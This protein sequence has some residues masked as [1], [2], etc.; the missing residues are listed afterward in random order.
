MANSNS[1]SNVLRSVANQEAPYV[2]PRPFR[3]EDQD[4][5]FGRNQE[6]LELTSL[7][8][9]HPEVLLYAP[10]GA[11]KSSLLYA[12]VMPILED[13]EEFDVLPAAR[14]RSQESSVIPDE[15]INNI[16]VFNAL[17]DL[18]DDKLSVMQRAQTTLAEYLKRQPRALVEGPD[19]S[20][21]DRR[22]E[23]GED[24]HEQR[25]PRV[26]VFDQFEEIF[27]LYPERYQDRQDFFCQVA[28]ALEGD[29]FLRVVFSMRED[30]IAELEPYIDV[31]PQK[32]RTRFR[33][34]RLRKANAISAVKQPLETDRVKKAGRSFAPGAA[35]S[36][37]EKLMLIK[38]K[39]ASG[40]KK[41]VPGEFVDPVQLQVVCQ[42][43]WEKLPSTETVI[44]QADLDKYANVDEALLDFYENSIRKAVAAS[45][46]GSEATAGVAGAAPAGPAVTEGALRGWFEQV[47]ITRE[48]KRNMVF[49]E[50]ETT[51]GLPNLVVD[52]L[53]NQHLVRVEMRG[54]EPWYELSHDRFIP[55]IKES[56]RRWLL[57]QPLAQ[58]KA[59]ELEA[60]ASEWLAAGRNSKLLLDRGQLADARTWLQSSEAAAIGYSETLYSLI[61]ESETE[62]EQEDRRH[63]KALAAEQHRRMLAE[64]QRA[65]QLKVGFVVASV[66]LVVTAVSAVSAYRAENRATKNYTRAESARQSAEKAHGDAVAAQI[67]EKAAA[68]LAEGEAARATK[69]AAAARSAANE[70][71]IAKENES[72]ARRKAEDARR[73]AETDRGLAVAA[74]AAAEGASNKLAAA[75]GESED[76]KNRAWS[77]KLAG[78]SNLQLS[79]DP[80]LGLRLAIEAVKFSQTAPATYSL[81]QSYLNSKAR[82]ILKGH[83]NSVWQSV[84]SPDGKFIFTASEDGTVKMWDAKTNRELKALE[85]QEDGVHRVTTSAD[86]TH[87][88]T[89]ANAKGRVWNLNDGTSIVLDGLTGPVAAIAFS[90]NGKLVATEATSDEKKPG[91]VP[92]IWDATSGLERHKLEGHEEAVSAL[93][94]S[95]DGNLLATSSW[96]S[97]ARIWDVATGRQL[98]I[99]R[100]HTAP[101]TSV[102]FDPQGGRLVTG[103]YDGTARVWE[104][105]TGKEIFALR[106]E[107]AGG[108]RDV[109][110]SPNGALILTVGQRLTALT[111]NNN[112]IPL[113]AGMATDENA[114]ADNAVRVWDATTGRQVVV[115]DGLKMEANQAIFSPD[116]RMI[117]TA[118][119]DGAVQLW[120]I[121]TGKNIAE[122]KGHKDG[123][124]SVAFSPDGNSVVTAGEDHTA[125]VWRV[126]NA[127]GAAQRF[128]S[129]QTKAI[130]RVQ[131][132]FNGETIVS[133]S[134]DGSVGFWSPQ[135]KLKEWGLKANPGEVVSDVAFSPD[136][137]FAV[138]ASRRPE[139]TRKISDEKY[140]DA[141]VWDLVRHKF[142]RTLKP[143]QR[144]TKH[145]ERVTRVEYSPNGNYALTV[146][147]DGKAVVWETS[148]W[149]PVSALKP[150]EVEGEE[151]PGSILA[152]CFDPGEKLVLTA[153]SSGK[154][155]VWELLT[156]TNQRAIEAH[157]QAVT[158]VAFNTSGDR[159]VTTSSDSTAR[160]WTIDGKNISTLNGHAGV[161]LSAEFSR[162]GD[163]IV[164]AGLDGTVR[165]WSVGSGDPFATVRVHDGAI[166]RASFSPDG[167]SIVMGDE[168]GRLYLLACDVC[169]P[170]DDILLLAE[171]L[172]PRKLTFDE[173]SHFVPDEG[174][175]KSVP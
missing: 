20:G 8:K 76:S 162:K 165:L 173:W 71:A 117:A 154:V 129:R 36:L 30:Y 98:R 130:Q 29:P 3:R 103:S 38:V 150:P 104:V 102:R 17:K 67:K 23:N 131:F 31:L 107:H 64:H 156:G 138:I 174:A 56:N 80:E 69:A 46:V 73:R 37:V 127:A 112:Q 35:E 139:V 172:K 94:F 89:E 26:V 39:T 101:L 157:D 147:A 164:T 72:A 86:G 166:L 105:A 55:P 91:A 74:R 7:I 90:P 106:G 22:G 175:P 93:A 84:Y 42:T 77:F 1:A 146:S 125:R 134:S 163:F 135:G 9:A 85:G 151:G 99:L 92:R 97:T 158:S 2:G 149:T 124:N 61:K 70:L 62:I 60:R 27:T 137:K 41:E 83:T 49:R 113:P 119:K 66:L 95:P 87:I 159:I 50:R 126:M 4:I 123:V 120:E 63:E 11:G 81:R 96:D 18:S 140:R 53:E 128:E 13:E 43:L 51:R 59:Q 141:Q 58:R 34:E 78:D 115:I 169:H 57:Q 32:L 15:K 121:A 25:L 48:G 40:E 109:G 108:V 68:A 160:V 161:V 52:E 14:V 65:R 54:G 171:D 16:Y 110:L 153:H 132:N 116:S 148:Y 118:G 88:A 111:A 28:D 47:L 142:V 145:E 79:N 75:L 114:P 19:N 122:L 45:N 170:F 21:I 136:Y 6:A 44:D 168:E 152:G 144:P 5:F 33:L 10:S 167:K 100:G 143:K 155:L 12:L 82:S 133:A 24:D